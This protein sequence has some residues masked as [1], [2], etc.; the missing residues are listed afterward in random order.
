MRLVA[1]ALVLCLGAVR[2]WQPLQERIRLLSPYLPQATATAMAK[3][4]YGASTRAGIEPELVAAIVS[5]ESNF[6]VDALACYVVYRHHACYDTCDRGLAQINDVWVRA[7]GLSPCRLLHD[8]AYN[9]AQALRILRQLRHRYGATE[10]NWW[11]RYNSSSPVPRAI[12]E[13]VL[14]PRLE[15]E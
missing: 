1:L 3:L 15:R 6:R 9:L 11:S 14:E 8:P 10:P 7:W 4:I 2:P 13:A 5:R 12:Y